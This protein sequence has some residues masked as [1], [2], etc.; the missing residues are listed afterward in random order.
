L[1]L[2]VE[3]I[4]YTKHYSNGKLQ[5]QVLAL[6]LTGLV[7]LTFTISSAAVVYHLNVFPETVVA[8]NGTESASRQ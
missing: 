6:T 8:V 2:F 1:P 5:L 7:Y 3:D 4:F